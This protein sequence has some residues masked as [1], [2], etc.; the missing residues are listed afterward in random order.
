[1]PPQPI[2]YQG[3]AAIAAFLRERAALRGVPL[4]AVPTRA[5]GHPAVGCYL[6]DAEAAIARPYGLIVLTLEGDRISDITWF[7]DTGVF[8][9]F[10]LPPRIH[11]APVTPY[12]RCGTSERPN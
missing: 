4:R 12:G 6:P 8:A 5:N 7:A 9:H 3:H 10:G 1:M 2:E 11:L